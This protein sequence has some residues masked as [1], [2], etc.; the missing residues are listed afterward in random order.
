MTDSQHDSQALATLLQVLMRQCARH[1]FYA[2]TVLENTS[3]QRQQMLLQEERRGSVFLEV[4]IRHF[5][6]P[7]LCPC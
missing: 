2:V 1:W 7:R 5:L 4:F 3:I 6:T